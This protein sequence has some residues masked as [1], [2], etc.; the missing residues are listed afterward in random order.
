MDS[1]LERTRCG[2]DLR[3]GQSV[4]EDEVWTGPEV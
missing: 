2:L 4:R 1:Q 3:C